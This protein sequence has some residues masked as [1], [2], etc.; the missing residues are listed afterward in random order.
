M[1]NVIMVCTIDLFVLCAVNDLSE[2]N[3]SAQIE[4]T[5]LEN[6]MWYV[7]IS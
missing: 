4:F 7:L 6:S 2:A 3:N 1:Q 5:P